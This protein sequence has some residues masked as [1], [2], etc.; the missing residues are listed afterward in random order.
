[1][2]W[3]ADA[4]PW[5]LL[6]G[7]HL[8]ISSVVY[9][10]S[11]VSALVRRLGSSGASLTRD[12]L[13]ISALKPMRGLDPS[14][15]S[16][17]ESF[18]RLDV[19]DAFEVL[20]L[21]DDV[22]DE[23]LPLAEKMAKRYPKRFRVI[24]GTSPGMTNPKVASLCHALPFAKNSLIWVTDSNVET[25][26]EHLRAQ[27]LEWK[28]IQAKGRRPTLI[29]APIAAV[30]GSGL[31]AR[32][33]RLQLATYNTVNAETTLAAGIDAVVG[34]SLFLHR[35]DLKAV[36]GLEAFAAAS[37]EDF[38]MGRAFHQVGVVRSARRTTRQVLGEH[39]TLADFWKRQARWAKVRHR[40][41]PLA[42]ML[43]EPFSY[44][45]TAF[46]WMSLGLLPWQVVAGV[47]GVKM[48]GDSVLML[49]IAGEVRLLD[50]VVLPLKEAVLLLV[51]ASTFFTREVTWRGRRLT[52]ES[53]GDYRAHV[54]EPPSTL[55]P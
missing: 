26:D 7:L 37:G 54:V 40:M 4:S 51:W 15:E 5:Q 9:L 13:V 28:G 55:H 12:E 42:F 47:M 22:R 1:M 46:L 11:L 25:S 8:L 27:M 50:V 29:H 18:A 44:F 39:L 41:T 38:L 21:L 53:G 43:L 45:G 35:D 31:G 3:L 24:V 14:L 36:G 16:N 34:K 49:A 20:L 33:E 52:V 19:P 32:L 23:A 2:S 30:G 17:L 6:A 48:A 10:P